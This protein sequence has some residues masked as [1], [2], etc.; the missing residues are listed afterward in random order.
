MPSSISWWIPIVVPFYCCFN[1]RTF[2]KQTEKVVWSWMFISSPSFVHWVEFSMTLIPRKILKN[3][4]QFLREN[5]SSIHFSW[6]LHSCHF[7]LNHP[8]ATGKIQNWLNDRTLDSKTIQSMKKH[9][10]QLPMS[11]MVVKTKLPVAFLRLCYVAHL[12]RPC[13]SVLLTSESSLLLSVNFQSYCFFSWYCNLKHHSSWRIL[14][15]N[16]SP[17]SGRNSWSLGRP[18]LLPR[19]PVKPR[20]GHVM[21]LCVYCVAP[22]TCHASSNSHFEKNSILSGSSYQVT[23]YE[24][25]SRQNRNYRQDNQ[26]SNLHFEVKFFSPHFSPHHHSIQH[27]KMLNFKEKIFLSK[28]LLPKRQHEGQFVVYLSC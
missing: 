22:Y 20:F 16:L 10:I 17:D 4:L 18:P 13:L 23:S 2:W 1:Q 14:L 26:I 24:S 25:S 28:V 12:L 9:C 6:S 8:A 7:S 21:K 27:E 5:D 19:S 15:P 11:I 3:T